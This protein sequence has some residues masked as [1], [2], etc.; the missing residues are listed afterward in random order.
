MPGMMK[1]LVTAK[2]IT[3]RQ[4]VVG[5]DFDNVNAVGQC[6]GL[7]SP[8]VVDRFLDNVKK[9]LN[10]EDKLLIM[11]FDSGR[12]V[13]EVNDIFPNID[14]S[15]KFTEE[16]SSH[17]LLGTKRLERLDFCSVNEKKLLKCLTRKI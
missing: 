7:R 5:N 4:E 9:T 16:E 1:I 14:I 17:Y 11:K 6:L 2:M 8:R 10:D 3:L 15:P 12:S 13:P